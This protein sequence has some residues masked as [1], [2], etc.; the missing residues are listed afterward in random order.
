[1]QISQKPLQTPKIN[2]AHPLARGLQMD[3][4]LAEKGSLTPRDTVVGSKLTVTNNDWFSQ[5]GD[6]GLRF[7]ASGEYSRISTLPPRQQYTRYLTV[8]VEFSR[9]SG[10]SGTNYGVI[11]GLGQSTVFSGRIWLLEND[12]GDGGW[13]QTLQVWWD[14][15][16]GIWSIPYPAAGIKHHLTVVYDG[17]STSNDPT[18]VL[19]GIRQTVTERLSPSG[20]LRTGGAYFAIGN[21]AEAGGAWDGNVY[22]LRTWNRLLTFRER[23]ELYLNPFQIY[24][25]HRIIGKAPA[26]VVGS[27]FPGYYGFGQGF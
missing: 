20:S 21:T 2:W 16:P 11:C 15:Q 22:R 25:N 27:T 10:G 1:M 26:V 24:Q 18:F 17:G 19:N 3:W 6:R 8:E 7:D 23:Q 12:N 5:Y 4:L 14:S 9:D 13:G